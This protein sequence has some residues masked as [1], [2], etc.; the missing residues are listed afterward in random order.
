MLH[1]CGPPER[2]ESIRRKLVLQTPT[3]AYARRPILTRHVRSQDQVR[4]LHFCE[5][6]GTENMA[7]RCQFV[8]GFIADTQASSISLSA[9]DSRRGQSKLLSLS[10]GQAWSNLLVAV[11]APTCSLALC[12]C[13]GLLLAKGHHY[14][15]WTRDGDSSLPASL[16]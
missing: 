8:A 14:C 11:S 4:L 9:P 1:W 15:K 12:I 16:T 3:T 13:L 2:P 6:A 5:L 10:H 7:S